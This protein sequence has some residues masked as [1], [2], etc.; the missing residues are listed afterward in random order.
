VK[1]PLFLGEHAYRGLSLSRLARVR[2]RILAKYIVKTVRSP[3]RRRAALKTLDALRPKGIGREA[4]VIGLG[5][6]ALDLSPAKIRVRQR[7]R[8]LDVFALNAYSATPLAAEVV[9]DYYVLTD[10]AFFGK[11][12]DH[13]LATSRVNP[14]TVWEYLEGH[15]GIAVCVPY[16]FEPPLGF[17]RSRLFYLN[18]IGLQG[19]S[20]N[21]DPAKPRGYISMT[22]YAA[23]ALAGAMGYRRILMTGIENTQ[24]KWL[25]LTSERHVA[26]GSSHAYDAGETVLKEIALFSSGGVPAFFEDVSRLFGDLRLFAHLPVV[27]LDQSTLIEY[28]PVADDRDAFCDADR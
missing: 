16:E 17:D 28:F 26:L 9:P 18:T 21:I 15:P 13:Y 8:S 1:E 25:A 19:F 20:R 22:S 3:Y 11:S 7:E 27:N 23:L 12:Q 14:T 10:P 6:S 5:P 4:L 2:A 24:F